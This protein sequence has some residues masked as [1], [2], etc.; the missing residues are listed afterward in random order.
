MWTNSHPKENQQSAW[1]ASSFTFLIVLQEWREFCGWKWKC[2]FPTVISSS[3]LAEMIS[4]L[5]LSGLEVFCFKTIS[6]QEDALWSSSPGLHFLLDLTLLSCI[7]NFLLEFHKFFFIP[8]L[9]KRKCTI[10]GWDF[11]RLQ[12]VRVRV[13]TN[14]VFESKYL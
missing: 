1:L 10:Q 14:Q 8:R 6:A 9:P 7:C 2:L 13:K 12:D 11:G 5:C 4:S 3:D